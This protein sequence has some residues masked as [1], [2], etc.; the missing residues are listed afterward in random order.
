MSAQV[1]IGLGSNLNHPLRQL[2]TALTALAEL[3][4]CRLLRHSHLY[5]SPP[6]G[7]PGQP[8]YV[9]AV[10]L[11]ETQ[12]APLDLLARLQEIEQRQ[13][14]IRSSERWGPRTLD[15]DLLLYG[16]QRLTTPRLELPHP[17]LSS[18][19]FVLVPLADIA[20]GKLSIPGSG[21]LD[22]LLRNCD[23]TGIEVLIESAAV[24]TISHRGVRLLSGPYAPI[25]RP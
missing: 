9:N 2:Q 1:F 20:D 10:A 18:R 6:L 15:L 3:P 14:R 11:L 23:R 4:G 25:R 22:E 12:I 24:R 21:R 5:R 7:P 16:T 8:E 17:R 19:A 13:G